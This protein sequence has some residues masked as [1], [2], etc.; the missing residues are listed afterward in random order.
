MTLDQ[1]LTHLLSLMED[2]PGGWKAHCWHRAK[3]LAK[4]P[5]LA[6]LP[7]LLET[8]MRER[9]KKSTPE[10]PC[11]EPPASTNGVLTSITSSASK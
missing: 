2:Y 10:P 7:T 4:R 3:E 8:A 9:S 5:E 11:T 6:E 1:H